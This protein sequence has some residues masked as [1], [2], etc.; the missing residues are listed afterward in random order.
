MPS[1]SIRTVSSLSMSR[2]PSSV[3]KQDGDISTDIIS[4]Y[5]ILQ[6][7]KVIYY[8]TGKNTFGS[9]CRVLLR[10]LGPTSPSPDDF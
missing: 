9:Q 7:P 1:T 5:T 2:P 3:Y 8:S 4:R 6:E 10:C